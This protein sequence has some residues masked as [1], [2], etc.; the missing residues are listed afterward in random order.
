MPPQT[1]PPQ[2]SGPEHGTPEGLARIASALCRHKVDFVAIGGWAVEALGF[3]MGYK[4][5]DIDFAPDFGPGN[6]DRLSAALHSL[7][8]RIR[9]AGESLPFDHNGQ[10]L[11]NADI[12]NLTCA[13]GDFDITFHP[14]GPGGYPNLVAAARPVT[15][16]T[17]DGQID[18]LCAGIED[19]IRSKQAANRPKDL[20]AVALLQAQLEAAAHEQPGGHEAAA[21]VPAA[22]PPPSTPATKRDRILAAAR[23]N[24]KGT[25]KQIA[26]KAG[27]SPGYTAAVLKQARRR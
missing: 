21:T 5:T 12:W 7:G 25:A 19:I 26:R 6:L 11:G 14:S 4:T 13:Y 24:P 1:V 18:V 10:S 15:I 20:P 17:A 8:A 9:I 22:I 27:A 23:R 3:D 2:P 16:D